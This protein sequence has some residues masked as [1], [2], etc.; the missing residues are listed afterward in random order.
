MVDRMTPGD[1]SPL[2]SPS[3]ERSEGSRLA[4]Y[5]RWLARER[6]LSFAS[7][8]E[9]WRWSVDE[10]EAFW[11][12]LWDYFE[13]GPKT[14]TSVLDQR[15]MPGAHWF[16]GATLNY[17]ERALSQPGQGVAVI[18]RGEDGSRRQL[19]YAELARAVAGCRNGLVRLGVKQGDRVVGYLPNAPEALIALLA[20]ASLGAIWSSCPPEFGTTSVLD[21]FSQIAPKVLI[22]T[23]GY[24]YGGKWFD[25][26]DAVRELVAALP[27]LEA[28]VYTDAAAPEPGGI[29][30]EALLSEAGPL[31]FARVPFEHPL[32]ILFSSG[33]T[34]LPKPIVHGH[35]GMLLEHLK[36]LALHSDLGPNKRF[37]WFS[38]TGWMMWNYLVSGLHV[39]A[40]IVLYDGSPGFPDLTALW[41]LAAEEKVTYFGASAP[42][43]L[44]CRGAG[45]TPKAAFDLSALTDVGSTGAPLPA[46]GF[47]WV[48][49]SVSADVLL[50]S[51]SG[52]TDLCTAF[53]CSCPLLPV[54]K[55]EL[56]C[57][58]LGADVLAFSATGEPLEGEVGELVIARP[59]P[60]MPLYFWNDAGGARYHDSYFDQF[61]GVWRHGD[62]I[63]FTEHGGAVISGRSDATLNR[64][65]VRMG[66]SE[67]YRVVEELPEV[68]DAVVIDTTGSTGTGALWLFV[69]LRA[70]AA[71]DPELEKRIKAVLRGRL[72][73]RHVPDEIRAIPEVPRT[74]S[75][76]KLEVPIKRLLAGAKLESVVNPGTLANP[77][78]LY[79]LLKSAGI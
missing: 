75:G 69:V 26:S 43:L 50:A 66:T 42:F 31:T 67:F 22:A 65:G 74:L 64:G 12:S 40:T 10:L 46:E 27:S 4:D 41:R 45:I 32:W 72:S 16:A 30:F 57:R 29:S 36:V 62:W 73:P 61:P 76:K 11:E 51:V 63:R 23:R 6:G 79:A 13:L 19:T 59:M 44:A 25:R 58:A 71:L 37:F 48:Y 9:L 5:M 35:G 34:G 28:C 24:R 54:Y 2:W 8:A 38:T 53:V 3:R 52:G 1:S 18:H 78:A 33:T 55:G 60:C 56:Q 68:S 47:E 77:N 17:A 15:T 14:F 70:G 7:Y 39:G 20:C 49:S 21:R